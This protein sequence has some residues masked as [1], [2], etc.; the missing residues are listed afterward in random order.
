MRLGL[1]LVK[2]H[3]GIRFKQ[4]PFLKPYILLNNEART[5]ARNS[6]EVNLYKSYNNFIFGKTCYNVFKQIKLR[7]VDDED[8]F[9]RLVAKATYHSS[10]VINERIV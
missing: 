1:K 9:Q 3:R 8:V 2:I 6:F 10:D 5:R 7:L 4:A